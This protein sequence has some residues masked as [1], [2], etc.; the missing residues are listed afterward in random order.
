M[1][2]QQKQQMLEQQKQQM[3]EQQKRKPIH[4]I[5]K[6]NKIVTQPKQQ[7]IEY[8]EDS[9]NNNSDHNY[10]SK[11]NELELKE[12]ELNT[13]STQLQKM[14][15]DYNYLF[16]TTYIHVE[17]SDQNNAPAYKF[18]L[19]MDN[20][21]DI[22]LN[23]YSVP[24]IQLNIEENKNNYLIIKRNDIETKIN[25][26]KGKYTIDTLI[27]TLNDKLTNIKISLTQEQH[28]KIEDTTEPKVN[29]DLIQ[30]ELLK[31]NLGFIN[32][33]NNTTQY[34]SDNIW[35]LRINN[36]IYLYIR[37]LSDDPFGV[38]FADSI[39]SCQ[40]KFKEPIQF[41]MLD[42]E[43][44]DAKGNLYNFYNLPHTLSFLISKLK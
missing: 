28:I 37:N 39:T 36:K 7:I 23:Y 1:L 42:I 33:T 44:K 29:F 17:V 26:P 5:S 41:D 32:N 20:V 43:F 10:N 40:F 6:L 22:K 25:I 4:K 13:K 14:I 30:T 27:N 35:D 38:L 21:T 34:I 9:E 19:Y 31:T 12:L 2:E 3:L 24:N 16:N 15:N 11:L 8:E 18:P